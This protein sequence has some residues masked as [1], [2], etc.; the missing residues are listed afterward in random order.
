MN[1]EDERSSNA[2]AFHLLDGLELG[3]DL[4][5]SNG[6]TEFRFINGANPEVDYLVVHA[7]DALT[8]SLLQERLNQLKTG[9]YIRVF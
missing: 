8:L 1:R 4:K 3:P 7:A 2:Q 5:A 6:A 9:I